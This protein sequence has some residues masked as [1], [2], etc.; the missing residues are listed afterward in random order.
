MTSSAGAS[1][2]YDDQTRLR[3]RTKDKAWRRAGDEVVVLD[4]AQS[5]YHAANASATELW[6]ALETGA[7][8]AELAAVLQRRYGLDDTTAR[9]DIAVF[10]ADLRAADL[11]DRADGE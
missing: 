11:L 3:L 6:Q 2:E 7:T 5:T 1:E 9:R 10:L 4:V 8:P